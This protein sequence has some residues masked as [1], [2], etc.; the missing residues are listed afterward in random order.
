MRKVTNQFPIVGQATR[1][2]TTI[3]SDIEGSQRP[4]EMKRFPGDS[5]D[6]DLSPALPD[7]RSS[8]PLSRIAK[9]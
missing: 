7:T 3:Q 5:L 8:L 9:G 4:S 2:A 1:N 6:D